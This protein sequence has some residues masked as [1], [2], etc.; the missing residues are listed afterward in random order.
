MSGIRT[1]CTIQEEHTSC[2]KQEDEKIDGLAH[3]RVTEL[4][5]PSRVRDEAANTGY[6][7]AS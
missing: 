5:H 4:A 6:R 1:T 7:A 3:V 2:L